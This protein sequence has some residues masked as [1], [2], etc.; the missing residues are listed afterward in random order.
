MKK[1]T[2]KDI[3]QKLGVS[4]STVSRAL[5][6]HPDISNQVK[7][8]IQETAKLL[9]YRPSS[10][11]LHL[12]RGSNKVISL[13]VPQITSFFYPSVIHGIEDILQSQGYTLNI[14][15]TNDLLERE[16]E[17]INIAYDQDVSGVIIAVTKETTDTDHFELLRDADIPVIMFDK[18]I[19][20]A[21]FTS[22]TIDDFKV[23]Y[24]MVQHL[25]K[26]GCRKIVGLFGKAS[27]SISHLRFMGF[28]QALNDV[29]LSF[30]ESD[31]LFANDSNDAYVKTIALLQNNPDGLYIMTDEI[32]IGAMPALFRKNI[33]V[34][35]QVSIIAISDG[36]LPAYM[37]PTVSHMKHDGYELGVVAA[38]KIIQYI[39][40]K[41]N[42]LP[43]HVEKIM[44]N[45]NIKL[46]ESTR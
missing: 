1:I 15:T 29:N 44:M 39:N 21:P 7:N 24:Q 34:P 20:Q 23:S 27:L 30:N 38:Q 12:K 43:T 33:K 4:T 35:E 11:A 37:I 19:E 3:A 22:I 18:V 6:N 9:K 28:K 2:I 16:I 32:M 41:Q 13:I 26:S 42:N 17:N 31:A 25:F 14:L 8:Q 5:S 40:A 46:L 10:A 36:Y 45:T